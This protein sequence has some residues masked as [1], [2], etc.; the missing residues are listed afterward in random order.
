M[1]LMHAALF[2]GRLKADVYMYGVLVLVGFGV[3]KFFF[4]LCSPLLSTMDYKFA[5]LYKPLCSLQVV[6]YLFQL[7]EKDIITF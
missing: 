7:S 5:V 2:E 3:F 1:S 6:G 4:F